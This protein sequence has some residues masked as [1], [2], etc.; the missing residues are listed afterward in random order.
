MTGSH[1]TINSKGINSTRKR[2]ASVIATCLSPSSSPH[3]LPRSLQTCSCL[4]VCLH[5][6]RQASLC[7]PPIYRSHPPTLFPPSRPTFIRPSRRVWFGVWYSTVVACEFS[8]RLGSLNRKGL[9]S[10]PQVI[11]QETDWDFQGNERVCVCE[12]VWSHS[13]AEAW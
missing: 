12:C 3:T 4:A 11:T 9:S 7:L 10:A 2:G 1:H 8:L 13:S 5:P 6:G